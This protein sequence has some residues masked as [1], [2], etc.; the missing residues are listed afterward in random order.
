MKLLSTPKS[1]YL[2]RASLEVLHFESHEWQEEVAY[3]SDE[4]RFLHKLH[5]KF[6]EKVL[7]E[8]LQKHSQ[9]LLQK[10]TEFSTRIANT[11]TAIEEH[12]KYLAETLQRQTNVSD[13][14][15]RS[16]I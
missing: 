13:E 12:E 4:S 5:R 16:N 7:P 15:Y 9:E 11:K 2:L 6:M 1:E 3:I 10:L 8:H 14:L